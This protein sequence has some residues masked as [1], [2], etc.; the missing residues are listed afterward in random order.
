[1]ASVMFMAVQ[2]QPVEAQ[3]LAAE[4]PQAGPLPSGVT[5]Q[6]TLTEQAYLSFRP[7]PVGVGQSLLVNFWVTPGLASNNRLLPQAFVITITKPDGTKDIVRW[8]L[9]LLPV[10]NGLNMCLTWL[11]IGQSSLNFLE[12]ISLLDTTTMELNYDESSGATIVWLS[13]L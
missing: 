10:R 12:R 7:N 5:V 8:I 4:Q 1:M 11:E 9:S 13:L 3:T 2:V 6:A